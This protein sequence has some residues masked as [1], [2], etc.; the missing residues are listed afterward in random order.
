MTDDEIVYE[1][2]LNI[3]K[4]NDRKDVSQTQNGSTDLNQS[5]KDAMISKQSI[6]IKDDKPKDSDDRSKTLKS[7]LP[8]TGEESSR[9]S[10]FISSLLAMITLVLIRSKKLRK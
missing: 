7:I 6:N 5:F 4:I 3:E 1:I 9:Y 2:N 8:K 10:I